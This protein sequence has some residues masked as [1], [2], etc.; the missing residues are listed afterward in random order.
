MYKTANHSTYEW[1]LT[2][3]SWYS[4][5]VATWNISGAVESYVV[6]GDTYIPAVRPVL[7]LLSTA[8]IDANHAGTESD[9][10]VLS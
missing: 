3:S 1:M 10:Y 5:L 2:P 9:P 4:F 6:Y 7:N 8:L